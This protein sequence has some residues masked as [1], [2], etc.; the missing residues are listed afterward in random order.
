MNDNF[1]K[2]SNIIY[3]RNPIIDALKDERRFER[4][5]LR[6][7]L[8]GE[9]E[10]EIRAICKARDIPLK[11]VPAIKLDKLTRKR[12][13]QGIVGIGAIVDYQP[14]DAVIPH[15]YENGESPV[16]IL[17]D[18][19]QDVRNIGAIARSAEALGAHGIILSGNNTV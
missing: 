5:Y 16:L 4:I 13:H 12:N 2:G 10:K 1:K 7:S 17:L 9:F 18:N 14:L 15:I 19:V 8:T 11:K 3:G 6:D